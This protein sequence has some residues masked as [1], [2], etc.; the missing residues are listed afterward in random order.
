MVDNLTGSSPVTIFGYPDND[1]ETLQVYAPIWIPTS[2]PRMRSRD[3]FGNIVPPPGYQGSP[4][5]APPGYLSLVPSHLASNALSPSLATTPGTPS[6]SLAASQIVN[7]SVTNDSDGEPQLLDGQSCILRPMRMV[8]AR[9]GL[10]PPVTETD[11]DRAVAAGNSANYEGDTNLRRNASADIPESDSCSF[12]I[13]N[14]PADCTIKTL[15][16]AIR[17]TGRVYASRIYKPNK[18]HPFT[19]AA[20]LVFFEKSAAQRFFAAALR[21][22]PGFYVGTRRAY[23]VYHRILSAETRDRP[24]RS[25]VLVIT[26]P[27]AKVNE[28]YLNKHLSPLFSW[29][30]DEVVTI[31]EM[32]KNRCLEYRF[33][34]YRAQAESAMLYSRT[35]AREKTMSQVNDSPGTPGQLR[36]M[37]NQLTI[38]PANDELG[39]RRSRDTRTGEV[40]PPPGLGFPPNFRL[41]PTADH[42]FSPFSN[43]TNLSLSSPS[44]STPSLTHTNLS[45]PNISPPTISP[46]TLSHANLTHTNCLLPDVSPPN[47]S[48]AE[49]DLLI[50]QAAGISPS[51]LGNPFL[52]AN[53]SARHIPDHQNCS[54]Y[55]THL[56]PTT[57]VH[58]LLHALH[59]TATGRVYFCHV[60]SPETDRQRRGLSAAKLTFF[61]P[62]S[63]NLFLERYN[64]FGFVVEGYAA[65]VVRNRTKVA[66]PAEGLAVSRVLL[67]TGPQEIV[68]E[69]V[70][71]GIFRSS[72]EFEMDGEVLVLSEGEG[73]RALCWPFGSYRAQAQAAVVLMRRNLGFFKGVD[74]G[75]GVDPCA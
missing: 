27:T 61:T 35:E 39:S 49:Q 42:R 14:L 60:N 37:V 36:D 5:G 28:Q 50:R 70:L 43:N 56:P 68:E 54:L 58:T 55:L 74:V 51:Y 4:M 8:L 19:A 62:E 7:G 65:R 26:G 17:N 12:H 3:G 13:I 15:L 41:V 67:I 72:F 52:P 71:M 31:W 44:L 38:S 9:S 1:L 29:Q 18:D 24:N 75:Y 22:G 30:T 6:P 59:G 32:Q 66:R 40:I 21:H 64:A 34:S 53:H 2:T 33:G 11:R 23:V 10:L 48:L 63:A 25:R 47:I 16:G 45:P 46:P 69:G 73:K 57:T 20:K